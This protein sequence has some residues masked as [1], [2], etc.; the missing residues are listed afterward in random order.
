MDREERILDEQQAGVQMLVA[1]GMGVLVSLVVIASCVGA[2][3]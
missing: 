1:A 2:W 3:M